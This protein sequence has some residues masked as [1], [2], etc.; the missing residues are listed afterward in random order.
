MEKN[1]EQLH[2]STKEH[3]V[4]NYT[5]EEA[6]QRIDNVLEWRFIDPLGEIQLDSDLLAECIDYDTLCLLRNSLI[7]AIAEHKP[8]AK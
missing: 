3:T 6:L 8:L 1:R 4:N 7:K 2:N 5:L